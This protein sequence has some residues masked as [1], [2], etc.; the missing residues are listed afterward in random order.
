MTRADAL[1]VLALVLLFAL[2]GVLEDAPTQTPAGHTT[3][4]GEVSR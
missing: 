1:R 4:A 2:G 3:T